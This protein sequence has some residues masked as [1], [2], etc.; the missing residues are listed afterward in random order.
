MM[1]SVYER[2]MRALEMSYPSIH[3]KIKKLPDSKNHIAYYS[4]GVANIVVHGIKYYPEKDTI[5][6]VSEHIKEMYKKNPKF[7]VLLGLGLGYELIE[8]LKLADNKVVYLVAIE[9]DPYLFRALLHVVDI[10]QLL[11][12]ENFVLLVEP[13]DAEIN[14]FVMR[15]SRLLSFASSMKTITPLYYSTAMK[16]S[17]DYYVSKL[18]VLTSAMKIAF[19]V[20]GNDPEDSYIGMYNMLQNLDHIIDNAGVN[21]LFDKFH[22]KPA[23]IASAGPSLNKNMHLLQGIYNKALII[24]PDTSLKILLNAGMKPHIVT[25]LERVKGTEKYV[26]NLDEELVKD[27]YYAA[28]PVVTRTNFESYNGPKLIVYRMFDHFKWLEIDRGMLD[29]KSSSGNMAFRLAISFGCNPIILIGQDLAFSRDGSTHAVGAVSGS[30]QQYYHNAQTFEVE[31]ND[32]FP[33]RTSEKWD[34]FRRQYEQDLFDYQGTCINATEGGAK[35]QGTA[36]MPFSDAIKQYIQ[37]DFSPNSVIHEALLAFSV[38]SHQEEH[39]KTNRKITTA[40]SELDTLIAACE[41]ALSHIRIFAQQDKKALVTQQLRDEYDMITSIKVSLTADNT[42]FQ[43]LVVHMLQ[44]YYTKFEMD[45]NELFSR[46]GHEDDILFD[47]ILAHQ[48]FFEVCIGIMQKIKD[49]L[50]ETKSN[51]SST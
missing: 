39:E 35:I 13:S 43:L 36:I 28:C 38:A 41:N 17:K 34:L 18:R 33:I 46:N 12:Q 49:L 30:N 9:K 48:S 2:N 29:I 27:I 10:Q 16:I 44:S 32:G 19:R 51:R 37:E 24:V 6:S 42:T 21:L 50:N 1:N 22:N 7:T 47:A 15:R 40:L 25:S 23:V 45:I 20:L 14:D 31:G 26:N 11:S 8:T 3:K 5:H 4:D